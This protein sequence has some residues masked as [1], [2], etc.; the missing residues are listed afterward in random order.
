MKPY[1]SPFLSFSKM[2]KEPP[3]TLLIVVSF[4]MPQSTLGQG[5]ITYLQYANS[6]VSGGIS[7][8]ISGLDFGTTSY[9]PTITWGSSSTVCTTTSWTSSTTVLCSPLLTNYVTS[10]GLKPTLRASALS[11]PT[12]NEDYFTFDGTLLR[13]LYTRDNRLQRKRCIP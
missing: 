10:Q 12:T 2:G 8:T 7:I 1:W 11:D 6:A 5:S 3:T 9:T 13:I 4:F